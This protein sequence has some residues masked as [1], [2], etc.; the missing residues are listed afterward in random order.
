MLLLMHITVLM[1]MCICI[2]RYIHTYIPS[3]MSVKLLL[4]LCWSCAALGYGVS[5]RWLSRLLRSQGRNTRICLAYFIYI[6]IYNRMESRIESNFFF[7]QMYLVGVINI[8]QFFMCCK[9][10]LSHMY[11]FIYYYRLASSFDCA[12]LHWTRN[13][14]FMLIL[15]KLFQKG[16]TFIKSK[17]PVI[18]QRTL[19]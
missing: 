8:F 5:P 3:R 17:Y 10:S 9:L 1:Q 12:N 14:N 11:C 15:T 4:R 13:S 18:K 16:L 2:C 19:L 7:I 6:C